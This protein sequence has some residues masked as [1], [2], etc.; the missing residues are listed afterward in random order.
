MTAIVTR[1]SLQNMLDSSNADYVMHVVGRA[2]VAL[3][4]RQTEGEKATN[5]TNVDNGIGFAGCD[6]ISGT[7]TAK[8]YLK[9]RKL[10]DWQVEKWLKRGKNGYS[11]LS[12][13]HAQLNQVAQAKKV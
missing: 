7:L 13:Y 4:N 9:N 5:S 12:K 3:F 8:S 6:A 1:D 10:Q 11:R 2:L